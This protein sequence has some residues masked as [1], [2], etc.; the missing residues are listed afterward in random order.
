[1]NPQIWISLRKMS[2]GAFIITAAISI[3]GC[4]NS[5]DQDV[6]SIVVDV[7]STDAGALRTSEAEKASEQFTNAPSDQTSTPIEK[8]QEDKITSGIQEVV[9]SSDATDQT[10]VSATMHSTTST[11]ENPIV[12]S[13]D[14]PHVLSI[15]PDKIPLHEE[16]SITLTGQKLDG[17]RVE[18]RM[19]KQESTF[20][21][22]LT[23]NGNELIIVRTADE[24]PLSGKWDIVLVFPDGSSVEMPEALE[25]Q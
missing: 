19:N 21:E 18:F 11:V 14:Q 13:S 16:T 10:S 1:M 3:T 4:N 8:S 12:P 20:P 24:A 23:N 5:A 2:P 15:T 6:G 9:S 22:V 17:A 25:I 7:A